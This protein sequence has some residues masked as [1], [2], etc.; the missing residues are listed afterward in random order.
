MEGS[1]IGE[2]IEG[3]VEDQINIRQFNQAGGYGNLRTPEQLQYLNNR[4]AW[5]KLASSVQVS[6]NTAGL[7]KLTNAKLDP[8]NFLGTKLAEKAILFNTLSSY[9]GT[10]SPLNSKRAGISDEITVDVYGNIT[11]TL[12]NDSFAY[13]IGGSDFGL[14]P[15]PGIIG[16][17][18]D[19][20][21]R[22]W[23]G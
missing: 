9:S 17:Q 2:K 6:S 14:Q 23:H 13:G 15:P 18:V 16:V 8:N 19:S 5:V 11:S 10:S 21:N 4:N 22:G 12:W 3:W 7:K 1:I 20:L